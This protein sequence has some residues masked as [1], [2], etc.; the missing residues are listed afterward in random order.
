MGGKGTDHPKDM[1]FMEPNEGLKGCQQTS[2][3]AVNKKVICQQ[4][5]LK[6]QQSAKNPSLLTV[7]NVVDVNVDTKTQ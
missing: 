5:P 3:F 7:D 2:C 4:N 6:R 1:G